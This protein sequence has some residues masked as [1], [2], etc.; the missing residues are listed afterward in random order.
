MRASEG[1]DLS[2]DLAAGVRDY[3]QSKVANDQN[4]VMK[5]LTIVA[6]LLLPASMIVGF[7]GMNVHG[8]S[9]VPLVVRLRV[10]HRADR[11]A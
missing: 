2:R 4:E 5:R 1:L 3:Y 10:R 11:A 9:R 7:Y 8:V 6:S